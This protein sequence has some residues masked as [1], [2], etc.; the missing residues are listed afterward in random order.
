MNGKFKCSARVIGTPNGLTLSKPQHNHEPCD[1]PEEKL[2]RSCL[3]SN[4]Y[5]DLYA[6]I[7]SSDQLE[8]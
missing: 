4:K 6:E 1:F 2:R 8:R 7:S 3:T 5:H